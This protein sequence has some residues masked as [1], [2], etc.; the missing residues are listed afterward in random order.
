MKHETGARRVLMVL[1]SCY[2]TEGGGG[3]ENQ[4]RTI[5]RYLH[6]CGVAVTV[7]APMVE[8]GEQHEHDHVDEVPLW[9]IPYPSVRKLGGFVMLARLAWFLYRNRREYDVIHA[10][11]ANQMAAVASVVG[12]LLGKTVIVKITGLLELADGILDSQQRSLPVR[13]KR[14]AMR[15]AD[16]FQATSTEIESR[17]LEN[18]YS[19]DAIRVIPNAVDTDR[20]ETVARSVQAR[21]G[22]RR[23]IVYVGRL[24]AVK[25]TDVLVSAWIEA[26]PQD[27]GMTLILVGEGSQRE[28]LQ[29]RIDQANRK[30][31]RLLG[32][33]ADVVPFL[34]DADV[35]ILPSLYEGL[36]NSLLEYL[37]AGLPV[38]GTRVSGTVDFIEPGRNGWLV[39]S[40]DR[41]Q[42]I[43]TLQELQRM[44]GKELHRMG[45][46]ARQKAVSRTSIAAVTA[47]LCRLYKIDPALLKHLP[48]GECA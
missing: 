2:P 22:V 45:E 42:L 30:D 17:L 13:I 20:F 8:R 32:A 25:G 36:S 34:A 1:E 11:I 31:I 15:Y 27:S 48:Q 33:Q 5:S 3:A 28:A 29:E 6:G 23:Q 4:V 37:A 41:E 35:A 24:E 9:R 26:F 16:Y 40:G 7:V 21:D 38:I 47:S 14:Q 44:D 19:G 43:S 18:G 12:R 39:D 10:H 46:L